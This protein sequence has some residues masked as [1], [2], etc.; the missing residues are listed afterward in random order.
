M[1]ERELEVAGLG[2]SLAGGVEGVRLLLLLL[3]RDLMLE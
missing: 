3:S 2:L 1:T